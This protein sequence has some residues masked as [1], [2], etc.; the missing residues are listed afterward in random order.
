MLVK[1]ICAV[2]YITVQCAA[3]AGGEEK[4][5]KLGSFEEFRH[6]KVGHFSILLSVFKKTVKCIGGE[7]VYDLPSV[8]A[9][10]VNAES[11]ER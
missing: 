3:E 6:F 2:L 5:S 9:F 10:G 4:S 7:C 11:F 8:S 1:N